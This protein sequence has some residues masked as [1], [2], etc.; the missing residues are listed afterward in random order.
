MPSRTRVLLIAIAV[1][2]LTCAPA[3]AFYWRDWPGSRIKLPDTL[4]PDDPGSGGGPGGDFDPGPG[5]GGGNDPHV[6]EPGTLLASAMGLALVG[7]RQW[8]RRSPEA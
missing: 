6:P 4:I 3:H 7:L 8:R 2:A 5:N 1:I